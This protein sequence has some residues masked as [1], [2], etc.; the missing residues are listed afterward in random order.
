MRIA[1]L[2]AGVA[3]LVAAH[4]LS[5]EGHFCDVYERWPGLG[6]QAATLDVGGGDLLE[7]YYHHLFTSDRHIVALYE[8]LGM[9]DELQ[10]K[11]STMAFFLDGRQWAFN[12]PLDLL[13]FKPLSPASRLRMGL[14]VLLLQKR[15]RD[16]GPFESITAREWIEGRMG[17]GPWRKVWGPLLRG[18]FGTRAEDISMAWLWSK[19]TLR[20]QLEGDE[21]RQEQL[22][23]PA[24]S[25]ELLF[26]ALRDAITAAGGRVLTDRPAAGLRRAPGG[27][28]LVQAGAAGSFRNG[29][30]PR[31][32]A[33]SEE[34]AQRYD[35]VVATVPSDVFDGLLDDELKSAIGPEY[36]GR[37]RATEYHTALCLLLELDRRFSPFY[38][39]NIA[40]PEVPF[41]GLVEHTNFIDPERYGGRRFLYVANYLAP[42]DPLLDLDAEQLLAA[43]MPGLR[44]VSPGFSA[45]WIRARWLHREPAAQPIVTVGYHRRIPPLNTGV[46][47]LVL[48]NTTQIYPEDRGTNYS[49]RLGTDAARALL[50]DYPSA[51]S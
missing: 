6:G 24:H 28:L 16:V 42:G 29:H 32:F 11:P 47:G 18:K 12:G 1:V 5:Q 44:K 27:G 17:R 2:G 33:P 15:A 48:A 8:E 37:L 39:T 26:D 34:P 19:L 23:Y 22:G 35:A 30:D 3:G 51:S 20:R 49:V 21:A 10:W 25:W 31:R 14:A 9:P 4:R 43:Y 7:R 13:R 45:D 38:W 36:L 46:P 41:V 40:D 50:A